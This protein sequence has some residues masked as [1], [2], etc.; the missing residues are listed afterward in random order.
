M[1]RIAE[2]S[3][4]Q[5]VRRMLLQEE[6]GAWDPL[7]GVTR[8]DGPRAWDPGATKIDPMPSARFDPG[9]TRIDPMP[10]AGVGAGG[11]AAA[12]AAAGG[13]TVASAAAVLG[14]ALLGLAVGTAINSEL[15]SAGI[16][17]AVIKWILSQRG[18]GKGLTFEVSLHSM[19]QG[20]ISS[21]RQRAPGS[22]IRPVSFEVTGVYGIVVDP[23]TNVVINNKSFAN[24]AGSPT[25]F[26]GTSRVRM[27]K[28]PAGVFVPAQVI[29]KVNYENG[30]R[31]NAVSGAGM[32]TSVPGTSTI[33]AQLTDSK[34]AGVAVSRSV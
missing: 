27:P 6:A 2:S 19:L 3:L 5:M 30:A 29:G 22:G 14:A 7:N 16:N 32:L 34:R 23:E 13:I 31:V 20:N 24:L 25:P 10:T 9:A 21:D 33:R 4:R 15:E 1:S 26:N 11:A 17:D 18:S 8:V 28:N 12:E